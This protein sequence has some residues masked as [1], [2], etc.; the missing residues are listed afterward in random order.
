[1]LKEVN[2]VSISFTKS[3]LKN[4]PKEATIQIE[5]FDEE[6]FY[7]LLCIDLVQIK[8]KH[9]GKRWIYAIRDINYDFYEN[10]KDEFQ[11]VINTIHMRIKD[12]LSRFIDIGNE[13]A[14]ADHFSKVYKSV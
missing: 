6:F 10:H 13:R 4:N 9:I 5:Y 14:L 8:V 1:M 7:E 3:E 11:H 12:Y 2:G